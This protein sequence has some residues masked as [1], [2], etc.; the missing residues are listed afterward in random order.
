[1]LFFALPA[2]SRLQSSSYARGK[3]TGQFGF[4][5]SGKQFIEPAF[6]GKKLAAICAL[7]QVRVPRN[8]F[9]GGQQLAAGFPGAQVSGD[10]RTEIFTSKGAHRF[11]SSNKGAKATRRFSRARWIMDLMA[12]S[13]VSS[14]RAISA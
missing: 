14:A 4:R 11:C 10:Q 13:L 8:G 12:F 6:L 9:A 5:N 7:D 2:T 1:M 3:R